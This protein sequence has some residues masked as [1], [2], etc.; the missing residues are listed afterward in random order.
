MG[1]WAAPVAP[2]L[3][4]VK[5]RVG[6][7]IGPKSAPA[8]WTLVFGGEA[9]AG[10]AGQGGRV[11]VGL[12]GGASPSTAPTHRGAVFALRP[13]E[14]EQAL[15]LA[16]PNRM[17]RS[18]GR[19]ASGLDFKET[20]S[21]SCLVQGVAATWRRHEGRE[22]EAPG[23]D[24]RARGSLAKSRG[25]KP[26]KLPP[27]GQAALATPGRREEAPTPP[28]L[29]HLHR[30]GTRVS[31]PSP[32][33]PTLMAPHSPFCRRRSLLDLLISTLLVSFPVS[34]SALLTHGWVLSTRLPS[35]R[36]TVASP[37]SP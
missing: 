27:G 7:Q 33:A 35:H 4:G 13:L 20:G 19:P 9:A 16:L 25:P 10:G 12:G 17:G 11:G 1:S 22:H 24:G 2:P 6:V 34:F 23:P 14:S 3:P 26:A 36:I 15:G 18:Y 28:A 29:L 5:P 32:T 8:P 37:P 31:A 30:R 21:V